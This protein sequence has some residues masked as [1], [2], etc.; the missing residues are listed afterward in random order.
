MCWLK[1]KSSSCCGGDGIVV[2]TCKRAI[3]SSPTEDT[4]NSINERVGIT[5]KSSR[6]LVCFKSKRKRWS[7]LGSCIQYLFVRS[8]TCSK[9]WLQQYKIRGSSKSYAGV[10]LYS[11]HSSCLLNSKPMAHMFDNH[12]NW[13]IGQVAMLEWKV[14]VSLILPTTNIIFR[15][16]IDMFGHWYGVWYLGAY[17]VCML[18]YDTVRPKA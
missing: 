14:R 9:K 12:F 3:G 5:W 4:L 7:V 10:G 16:I 2:E 13:A 6:A 1:H 8:K 17:I 15:S 11:G 18:I